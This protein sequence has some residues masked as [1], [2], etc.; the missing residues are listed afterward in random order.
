M[1]EE[2]TANNPA[3]RADLSARSFRTLSDTELDTGCVLLDDAYYDLIGRYPQVKVKLDAEKLLYPNPDDVDKMVFTRRVVKLLCSVV[4]RV[5][6]NPD[7]KFEEEGDD[8][9]YRR[10]SAI[11]TGEL[12]FSD[13]EIEDLLA[14]IDGADTAFT[15]KPKNNVTAPPPLPE[16]AFWEPIL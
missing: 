12:Y 5:I 14:N 7:G 9:R 3:K 15:I 1:A 13:E 10:D 4:L 11:S 2:T 16:D 8:Y 6:K